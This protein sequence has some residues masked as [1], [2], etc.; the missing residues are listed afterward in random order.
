MKKYKYRTF[1]GASHIDKVEFIS[2]TKHTVTLHSTV[3]STQRH[4]KRSSYQNYFDTPEDA[5]AFLIREAEKKIERAESS[6]R[7]AQA[8]LREAKKVELPP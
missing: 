6:L 2:E 1:V 7:Y 8:Q 3:Y 4:N 5:K